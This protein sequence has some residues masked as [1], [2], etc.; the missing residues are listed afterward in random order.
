MTEAA[1]VTGGLPLEKPGTD[2]NYGL[3]RLLM[4]SRVQFDVV[5][6]DVPWERYGL[7]VLPDAMR[8]DAKLAPRLEAYLDGGGA[9]IAS[10]ESGLLAGEEKSWL[11]RRGIRFAGMSKFKPAYMIPKEKFTGDIPAYE[12]ALYEGASQWSA[13]APAR[14][15]AALGEP[16]FQRSGTQYTSHKQTPFEGRPRSRRSP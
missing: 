12:Y 15:V 13:Q 6:P 5:E 2:G 7:I 14:V 3:V 16:A 9:V 8:L 10:H 1:L 11:E 4:E